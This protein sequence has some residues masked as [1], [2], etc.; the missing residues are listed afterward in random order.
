[1]ISK[2][3]PKIEGW[4]KAGR[5]KTYAANDQI[6][7]QAIRSL[8]YINALLPKSLDAKQVPRV[9]EE[10][11]EVLILGCRIYPDPEFAIQIALST[12]KIVSA[13]QQAGNFSFISNILAEVIQRA[14]GKIQGSLI[15]EQDR[16]VLPKWAQ[17]QIAI[18]Q[19]LV[20]QCDFAD[21]SLQLK[22]AQFGALFAISKRLSD[23]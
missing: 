21:S 14:T 23:A 13:S 17:D 3:I 20:Y 7:A 19:D 16:T 6:S 4:Q 22:R 18:L 8:T 15:M 10:C 2:C 1:M 9:L 12:L 5:V 11:I